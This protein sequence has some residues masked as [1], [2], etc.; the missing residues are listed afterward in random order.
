MKMIDIE[1]KTFNNI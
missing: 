1:T